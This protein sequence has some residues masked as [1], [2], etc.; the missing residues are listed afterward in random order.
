MDHTLQKPNQ[1]DE[2][3]ISGGTWNAFSAVAI[4]LFRF[5]FIH[6]FSTFLPNL[7][8]WNVNFMLLT[9]MHP[10]KANQGAYNGSNF[11]TLFE[12]GSPAIST[13]MKINYQQ[14]CRDLTWKSC[15]K[16]V[17]YAA[18]SLYSHFDSWYTIIK[19]FIFR[20]KIAIVWFFANF[21]CYYSS[22]KWEFSTI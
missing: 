1:S 19:D 18:L 8:I 11:I 16:A 9:L 17:S 3:K 10:Y 2:P 6:I 12:Q 5:V 15:I 4:F 22:K 20:V 21:P 13:N 7:N 14:K